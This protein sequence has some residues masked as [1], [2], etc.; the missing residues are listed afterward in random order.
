MSWTSKL[1]EKREYN[2]CEIMNK[3]L[4]RADCSLY[5]V[6]M[7][8][9]ANLHRDSHD[10]HVACIEESD[11]VRPSHTTLTARLDWQFDAKTLE[12]DHGCEDQD[13]GQQARHIWKTASEKGFATM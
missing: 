4:E 6:R 3:L 8:I 5:I 1:S 12:V 9:S 11:W 13:G 10:R 2:N 7:D